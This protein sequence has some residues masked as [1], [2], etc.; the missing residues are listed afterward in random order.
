MVRGGRRERER[1]ENAAHVKYIYTTT[2]ASYT[3]QY[4]GSGTQ[5]IQKIHT[6]T[7]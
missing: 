3:S 7:R 5:H 2:D 1:R 4:I 6:N